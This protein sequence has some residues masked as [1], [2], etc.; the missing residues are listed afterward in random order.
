MI[1]FSSRNKIDY[2]EYLNS[3][4]DPQKYII[5][6]AIENWEEVAI[7]LDVDAKKLR[8]DDKIERCSDAANQ[9]QSPVEVDDSIDF[10]E[11]I[12]YIETCLIQLKLDSGIEVI[13]TL[14]DFIKLVSKSDKG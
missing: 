4:L 6:S 7:F 14:G 2:K 1:N 9:L 10:E 3:K 5:Q 12:F 13:K 11:L 8:W